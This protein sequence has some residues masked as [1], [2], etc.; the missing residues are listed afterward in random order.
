MIMVGMFI[1]GFSVE[2]ML[3]SW[4]EE[5]NAQCLLIYSVFASCYLQFKA[6]LGYLEMTLWNKVIAEITGN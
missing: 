3:L 5:I 1:H 6:K 4:K 2:S